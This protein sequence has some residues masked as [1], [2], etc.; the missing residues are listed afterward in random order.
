MERTEKSTSLIDF[1]LNLI[2]IIYLFEYFYNVF[3]N[4]GKEIVG[5]GGPSLVRDISHVKE[6]S[7]NL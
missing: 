5:E 3:G 2:I 6:L 4:I 1:L 7:L